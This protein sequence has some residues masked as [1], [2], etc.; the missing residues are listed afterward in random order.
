MA[1]AAPYTFTWSPVPA[2]SYALTAIAYDAAGA[3][4]S[5]NAARIT[6]S[7][8]GP[9]IVAFT[10]SADH[11]TKVTS[12]RLDVF[13]AGADP[14]TATPVASSDLG[15]PTPG[16]DGDIYIERAS[17]FRALAPGNYIATVSAVGPGGS[18]RSTPAQFTR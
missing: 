16:K 5:S 11:D 1:S 4:A 9:A 17:F 14:A 10:P 6:V 12:Y 15:K 13:A 18:S 2:G 3:S 8:S 7:A